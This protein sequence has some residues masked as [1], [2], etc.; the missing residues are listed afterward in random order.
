MTLTPLIVAICVST[1]STYDKACNAALTQGAAQSGVSKHF[2]KTTKHIAKKTVEYIDPSKEAELIASVIG[3]S[4]KIATDRE[5]TF[6]LG[7]LGIANS[8]FT[9]TVGAE[10]N[11]IGFRIDF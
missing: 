5:A 1:G 9:L 7:G 3:Y 6:A 11:M 10:V 4:V 2:E 8:A